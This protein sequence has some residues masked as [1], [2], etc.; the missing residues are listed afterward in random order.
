VKASELR[1]LTREEIEAKV[2]EV[3]AE[4]FGARVRFATG[5]LENTARLRLLRRDV[6]R[7]ET[8]LREKVRGQHGASR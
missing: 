1:D 3:R 5:Q 6:A 4:Y 8:V 2:R 7:L